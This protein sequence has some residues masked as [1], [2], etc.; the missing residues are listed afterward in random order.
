MCA[1]RQ[2]GG[3]HRCLALAVDLHEARPHHPQR[4][5]DVGQVHR[6]AA[7]DDGLEG[8]GGVFRAQAGRLGMVDQALDDGRR[9]EGRQ[10][11]ERLA[12]REELGRVDAAGGR[13]HVPCAG[14]QVRDGVEAAAV[15]HRR[16][17]DDGIVGADRVDV[18]EIGQPHRHQVAVRQHHALRAAGGAAGVEEPG[19]V[20]RL[21]FGRRRRPRVG[22]RREQRIGRGRFGVDLPLQAGQRL[23]RDIARHEGPAGLRVV[24]DPRH[25]RRVQL[26]VHRHHHQPGPPGAP[27]DLQIARVVAHEDQHAVAGL[28]AGIAQALRQAG[29]ARGPL[30]MGGPG[31]RAFEDGVAVRGHTR[32]ACQQVGKGH[33]L[34]LLDAAQARHE[35]AVHDARTIAAAVIGARDGSDGSDGKVDGRDV[36]V[37]QR[38]SSPVRWLLHSPPPQGHSNSTVGAPETGCGARRRNRNP[39]RR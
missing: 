3:H 21:A 8:G 11:A 9:R 32:L 25:L 39:R 7:V 16:R 13:H 36:L 18:D 4:A 10:R 33:G 29:A 26:G 34:V 38:G 37:W 20:L 24:D 28:Q 17:V 12:E 14:H 1:A 35:G 5:P 22:E 6:R 23:G 19:Q 2:G 30:G 31:P 15:R 27:Q